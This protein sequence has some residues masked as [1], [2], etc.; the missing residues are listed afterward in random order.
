M[1]CLVVTHASGLRK[2]GR[3][4]YRTGQTPSERAPFPEKVVPL[5][6]TTVADLGFLKGGF[7][8][9]NQNNFSLTD[10]LFSTPLYCSQQLRGEHKNYIP[11]FIC[12][13]KIVHTSS[14]IC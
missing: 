10:Y 9:E 2:S 1:G 11:Y 12:K 13:N 5:I 7:K 14:L 3:C 4:L 6:Q 8:S